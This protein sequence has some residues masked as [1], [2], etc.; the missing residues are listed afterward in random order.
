M[1]NHILLIDCKDRKGL[2]YSITKV[3]IKHEANIIRN[4][5]YVD[6]GK[7]HF[8]MRTEFAGAFDSGKLFED[9][10]HELPEDANIHLTGRRKKNIIILAT[11][12][13]HCLGDLL[14]RNSF[15]E[16]NASIL[17]VVSNHQHLRDLTE[18]LGIPYHYISH[19]NL[20]REEHEQKI[21]SITTQYNP[22]YLVLA[23]YMRILSASFIS[24]FPNRIIN[25]HHSFLP[26]FVGANPYKQAFDRGVKIIGATAHFVNENLD[27]GPI[28][29]QGTLPVDHSFSDEDMSTA[30]KDVEKNVLSH[31]LKLV[32]DE[33]VIVNGNR[34][35]IFD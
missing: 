28:I 25:I 19:E 7:S 3:L 10:K 17:A 18:R 27:E 1:S 31:A 13:H 29:A 20:S 23:K 30:G 33:K 14:I 2:V 35:V 6:H 26:A 21:L 15:N 32:F 22:E 34:T 16:L 8:F 24:L 12:E 11:K 9:L 5:E 4:G